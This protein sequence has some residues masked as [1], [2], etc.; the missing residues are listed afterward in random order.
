MHMRHTFT[1]DRDCELLVKLLSYGPATLDTIRK[2]TL[3]QKG[4]GWTRGRL[5]LA[6]KLVGLQKTKADD[7]LWYYHL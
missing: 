1:S 6:V 4:I 7:G 5:R 2:R 3:G